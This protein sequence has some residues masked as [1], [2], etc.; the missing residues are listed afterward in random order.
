VPYLVAPAIPRGS[1]AC[2]GQP[3]IR[4]S[5]SAV[6]RP[7]RLGD[8]DAVIRAF[9]DPAIQWWHTRRLDSVSEA[10]ALISS[11]VEGWTTEGECHWALV[12]EA[13]GALLGRVR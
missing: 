2:S 3:S 13:G 4:V 6:L 10:H 12:A 11:W 7:W 1:L 5:D 9:E 8:A